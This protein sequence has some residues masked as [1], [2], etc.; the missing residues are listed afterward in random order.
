MSPLDLLGT[1]ALDRVVDDRL[2]GERRTVAGTAT[3]REVAPG[4][5]RWTEQGTMTWPGHAVPVA[6]TLEVVRLPRR[7]GQ[8]RPSGHP[9]GANLPVSTQDDA[10]DAW[11]VH[12]E[13]GRVFHPW[14]VGEDVEH[15]CA[16]DHYTGRIDVLGEGV[17]VDRWRVT[18]EARGPQKD[19]RMV[20][21]HSR[22]E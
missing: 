12:F 20:T 2:T 9:A 22:R 4:R 16:P 17:T 3:L 6:R 15:P 1:W 18:W 21:V 10:A 8:I 14:V 19:Y 5:V 11:V 13:D 7:D